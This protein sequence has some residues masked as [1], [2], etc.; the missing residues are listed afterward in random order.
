MKDTTQLK[1]ANWVLNTI[2]IIATIFI[3]VA[4]REEA[5]V[6]TATTISASLFYVMY[7]KAVITYIVKEILFMGKKKMP[8][9]E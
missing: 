8:Y 3:W 7:H 9:N 2:F 6:V 1:V 5:G 4:I